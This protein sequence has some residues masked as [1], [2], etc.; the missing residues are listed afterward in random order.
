MNIQNISLSS[1][2]TEKTLRQ[3]FDFHK[4]HSEH[5]DNYYTF[6]DLFEL[7]HCKKVNI[8]SLYSDFKYCEIGD[9]DKNGDVFPKT[10]NFSNRNLIDEDYYKKIEKGDITSI[11]KDNIL[12]AK[13]RPNLKKY[14]RITDSLNNIFL[15]Q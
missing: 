6:K 3:D 13:V 4:Y 11:E 14:I 10:L 2:S 1:I 9:T 12:I 15:K 7:V 8:E 5:C